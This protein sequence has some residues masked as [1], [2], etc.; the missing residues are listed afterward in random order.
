[1]WKI[2]YDWNKLNYVKKKLRV[3]YIQEI[4]S[5]IEFRIS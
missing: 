3:D 2:S 5:N 4:L 1:M